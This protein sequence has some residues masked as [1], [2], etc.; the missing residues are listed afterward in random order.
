MRHNVLTP[1]IKITDRCNLECEYCYRHQS[2]ISHQSDIGASTV[3][4][5]MS[6][7]NKA[8]SKMQKFILHGGE[9]LILPNEFF[10][11]FL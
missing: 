6:F 3:L 8:D 4:N 2:N 1:I 5:T 10:V 9:P 7:L 11:F